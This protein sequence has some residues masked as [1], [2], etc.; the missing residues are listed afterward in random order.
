MPEPIAR[1]YLVTPADR[2]CRTPSRRGSSK[3]AR[4]RASRRCCCASRRRRAHARQA[5][6]RCSRRWRRKNGAAVDRRRGRRADLAAVA[7][8]GGADGVHVAGGRADARTLRE[9]LA[10]R[11][12]GAGDLRSRHDAMDGGRGRRRLRHVRRAAR[13]RLA[14]APRGA[15]SSAPP[16]GPR[17]SRPRASPSRRR[18][19]AMPRPC[20]TGAEFVAI[21]DAVWDASGRR[22]RRPWQPRSRRI[23][24]PAE[25]PADARA[26]PS[27][28]PGGARRRPGR[29]RQPPPGATLRSR[30]ARLA[31]R[32]PDL[33][34]GAYQRGL[35]PHRPVREAATRLERDP[36]TPPP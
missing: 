11:I 34:Y 18:S 30:P 13:R 5:A 25:A 29:S 36:T 31:A 6:S 17:S 3:L 23:P 8:R 12:V 9:R 10:D 35:L 22:R 16:G 15:S 2:R 28:A 21:G 32:E 4:R 33:A 20:R 19:T 14:A 24:A 27:S 26:A 1:L 7:T